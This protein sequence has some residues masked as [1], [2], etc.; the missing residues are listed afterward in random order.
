MR[1]VYRGDLDGAVYAVLIKDIGLCDKVKIAHPGDMQEGKKKEFFGK[2][3]KLVKSI[4]I[5][6]IK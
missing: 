2:L 6:C 4:S 1:V 5:L 3:L